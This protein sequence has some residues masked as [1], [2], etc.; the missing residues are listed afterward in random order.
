MVLSVLWIFFKD[1]IGIYILLIMLQWGFL[2]LTSHASPDVQETDFLSGV[3]GTFFNTLHVDFHST[4]MMPTFLD[5][6]TSQWK[7]RALTLR[8]SWD[9]EAMKHFSFESVFFFSYL[10]TFNI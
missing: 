8:I 2:G 7:L 6:L 1:N 5:Q 3:T 4:Q 10:F 9:I